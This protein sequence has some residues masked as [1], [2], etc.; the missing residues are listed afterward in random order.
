[1]RSTPKTRVAQ[2]LHECSRTGALCPTMKQ[3]IRTKSVDSEQQ[4][5]NREF[6]EFAKPLQSQGQ[7]GADLS[8]SKARG[9]R[10]APVICP[11]TCEEA[12]FHQSRRHIFCF[13]S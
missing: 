4:R 9:Q 6:R 1:M 3:L 5:W 8:S 10:K 11:I 2:Q 7:A 12:P 13:S